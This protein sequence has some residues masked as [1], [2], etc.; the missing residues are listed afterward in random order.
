VTS[1]A[2][3]QAISLYSLL[4]VGKYL[5][6]QLFSLTDGPRLLSSKPRVKCRDTRH[7]IAYANEDFDASELQPDWLD[8]SSEPHSPK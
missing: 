6:I 4:V 2:V 5:G 7:S 3:K 1:S 8:G